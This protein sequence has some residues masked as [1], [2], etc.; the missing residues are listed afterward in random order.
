MLGPS[1]DRE[2]SSYWSELSGQ[3]DGFYASHWSEL[4]NEWVA[5]KLSF[6]SEFP[7][8]PS[9]LDLGCG[10]GLGAK[11]ARRWTELDGYIGVDIAPKMA[12]LTAMA[13]GVK[14]RVSPMDDL[15][16]VEDETVDAVICLFSAASFVSSPDRLFAELA[17]VLKPGGRAYISTLGRDF[18]Q[19][20]KKVRFRTRGHCSST[21]VPARRF[22]PEHLQQLAEEVGLHVGAIEGMNSLSGIWEAAPLWHAGGLV[23]R[24]FPVTS[25]LLEM[26]CLKPTEDPR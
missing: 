20:P 3:Y 25:H 24:A 8:P 26:I 6:L 13:F 17:R 1:W 10:T 11:L 9:I 7:A 15:S 21:S 19:S 22:R 12:E 14:T 18:G 16:W 2:Q 5:A 4:E 23:A